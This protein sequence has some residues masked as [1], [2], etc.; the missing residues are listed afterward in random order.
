MAKTPSTERYVVSDIGYGFAVHDTSQRLKQPAKA[1]DTAPSRNRYNAP[2]IMVCS[3]RDQ[4]FQRAAELNA[5]EGR[6]AKSGK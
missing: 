2:V 5:K 6:K 1:P 4:A 3:T